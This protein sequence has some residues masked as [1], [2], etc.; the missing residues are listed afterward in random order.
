MREAKKVTF[1]WPSLEKSCGS[2]VFR[3]VL[4]RSP[5]GVIEMRHKV[6]RLG[7]HKLGCFEGVGLEKCLSK[8]RYHLSNS[9]SA[10]SV[11]RIQR[12][13]IAGNR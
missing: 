8:S 3:T 11:L 1:C 6:V 13:R 12:I 2:E 10:F 4:P 9:C 7:L 5:G